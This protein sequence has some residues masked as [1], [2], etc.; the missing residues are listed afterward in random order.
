MSVYGTVTLIL[1]LEVF[2]GN[3]SARIDFA[4][5]LNLQPTSFASDPDLPGSAAKAGNVQTNTRS[6]IRTSSLH[7]K[8]K[9][10]LEY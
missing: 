7:R 1:A 6:N 9:V 5:R 2:L 4:R 3:S 10:V 8:I